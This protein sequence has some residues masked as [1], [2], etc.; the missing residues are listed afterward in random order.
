MIGAFFFLTHAQRGTEAREGHKFIHLNYL[1]ILRKII[2]ETRKHMLLMGKRENAIDDYMALKGFR[3]LV[4]L[5]NT[6]PICWR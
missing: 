5:P 4:C 1:K 3:T 6:Q 2:E